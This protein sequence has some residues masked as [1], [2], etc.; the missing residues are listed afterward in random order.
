MLAGGDVMARAKTGTGKTMAFLIPAI[1]ALVRWVL[2]CVACS[3]LNGQRGC[4]RGAAASPP[5]QHASS[6]HVAAAV[7]FYRAPPRQGDGI[8][9]LVL[10]PTRELASQVGAA[11]ACC[12]AAAGLLGC[13]VA[14]AAA[15]AASEDTVAAACIVHLR[16]F[17]EEVPASC[18]A[19]LALPQIEKEAEQLLRFHPFKA[20]VVYGEH[21]SSMLGHLFGV[22]RRSPRPAACARCVLLV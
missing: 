12:L 11:A 20:Q 14:A 15:A 5:S 18:S 1:E 2:A 6:N 21:G 4:A 7:P 10:S 19:P 3:C 17:S 16:R 22:Q 8:S 13:W 9:V